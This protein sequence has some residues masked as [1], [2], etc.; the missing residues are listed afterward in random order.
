[1]IRP[2]T[3]FMSIGRSQTK[4]QI[5]GQQHLN[6]KAENQGTYSIS[7]L[8]FRDKTLSS[9]GKINQSL[10][11]FKIEHYKDLRDRQKQIKLEMDDFNNTQQQDQSQ[12]MP[13]T[14]N[15]QRKI[16]LDHKQLQMQYSLLRN[17]ADLIQSRN[18]VIKQ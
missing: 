1:M 17:D 12:S 11:S 3:A 4:S 5:V 13:L 6:N 14:S 9:K 8:A 18:R 7:E 2:S 10:Q 16:M 15:Q